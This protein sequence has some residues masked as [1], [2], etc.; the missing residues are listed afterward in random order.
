MQTATLLAKKNCTFSVNY[1][2]VSI[3]LYCIVL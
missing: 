1:C 3:L 2:A